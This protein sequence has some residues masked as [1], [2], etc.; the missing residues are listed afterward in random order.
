M[1]L[2]TQVGVGVELEFELENLVVGSVVK[3][4]DVLDDL[5]ETIV[6]GIDFESV[7]AVVA[8]AVIG[9]VDVIHLFELAI[10]PIGAIVVVVVVEGLHY[11]VGE[12]QTRKGCEKTGAGVDRYVVKHLNLDLDSNYP[13]LII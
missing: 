13:S 1:V 9:V 7:A 11:Y 6:V 4:I 8:F 12:C 5:V 2:V 3:V 10:E